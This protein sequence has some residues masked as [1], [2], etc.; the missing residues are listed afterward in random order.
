[1]KE[2]PKIELK[3]ENGGY[4]LKVNGVEIADFVSKMEIEI[5]AGEIPKLKIE[6]YADISDV[7]LQADIEMIRNKNYCTMDKNTFQQM[8]EKYA[9]RK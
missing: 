3:P 8:K 4:S 9:M 7:L 1:M 6:Y 5:T 2:L